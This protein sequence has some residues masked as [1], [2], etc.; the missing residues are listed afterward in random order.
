MLAWLLAALPKSYSPKQ[1]VLCQGPEGTD[2][3]QVSWPA[4]PGASPHTHWVRAVSVWALRLCLSWSE[5]A[6]APSPVSKCS[7]GSPGQTLYL[8]CYLS[9]LRLSGMWEALLVS[10]PCSAWLG[11]DAVGLHLVG[12]SLPTLCSQVTV[13]QGAA[14]VLLLPHTLIEGDYSDRFR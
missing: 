9:C 12:S 14:L 5:D 7:V 4:S 8:P 1:S 6:S 13:P 3:S 11:L 10:S 2:C